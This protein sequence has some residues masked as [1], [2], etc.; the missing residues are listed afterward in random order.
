MK[1]SIIKP[2]S[3]TVIDNLGYGDLDLSSV[4]SNIYA[5]QFDTSTNTGHIEYNDGTVNV[6]D[7]IP[8]IDYI[9]GGGT[10]REA[11]TIPTSVEISKHSTICFFILST[12]SFVCA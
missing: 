5:I 9:L 10:A 4:A 1:I 12:L 11:S 8:L 6:L 2:D 3:M 7:L